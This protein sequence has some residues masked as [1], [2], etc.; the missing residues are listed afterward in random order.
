MAMTMFHN[1]DIQ[2]HDFSADSAYRSYLISRNQAPIVHHSRGMQ[3][4]RVCVVVRSVR[5][6]IRSVLASIHMALVAD[7]MRRARHQLARIGVRNGE[8]RPPL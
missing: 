6:H 3:W 8:T 2:A 5:N 4:K 7:K 1:R